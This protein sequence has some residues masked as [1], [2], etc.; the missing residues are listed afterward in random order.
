MPRRGEKR[1][2]FRQGL[3][4]ARAQLRLEHVRLY[5]EA[6]PLRT[7]RS[8]KALPAA[9]RPGRFHAAIGGHENPRPVDQDVAHQFG[10]AVGVVDVH[11]VSVGV[12]FDG[13]QFL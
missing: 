6:I 2:H 11:P 13:R 12:G 4:A 5:R 8:T 7:V 3:E 1:P 9:S 10:V